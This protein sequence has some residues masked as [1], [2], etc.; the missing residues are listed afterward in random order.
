ME[1]HRVVS[2]EDWLAARKALLDKEKEFTRL[3]DQLSQTR[4]ELPWERVEKGYVFDGPDGEA[5][6]ADLFDGRSQLVIYHFM[7]GPDWEAG[8]K[9]CSFWADNFNGIVDHL[10]RRDVTFAAISRAPLA[11][12]QGFKKR[13]NWSFP[14]YSS[15]RSDFNFD[16]GVSFTEN[17]IKDGKNRYNF[18]TLPAYADEMPG[19]S[20]FLKDL[21]GAVYHT[22]S[23]YA[24]GLDMQN[25]AYHYLDLV[26]KGRDEADLPYSMSWVR[27]RDE[28]GA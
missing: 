17:E 7:F 13:M 14:W 8:C 6:L 20:V 15:G 11:T 24:R 1:Q 10:S 22:Y 3:R 9:S 4:R 2:H 25:T 19:T 16:F 5:S 28:Y 18:K 21:D 26:P 12:L 23:C 27:L